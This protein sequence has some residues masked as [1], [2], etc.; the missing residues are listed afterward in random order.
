MSVTASAATAT[1]VAASRANPAAT[2]PKAQQ[3]I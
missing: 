2:L 1:A 3:T